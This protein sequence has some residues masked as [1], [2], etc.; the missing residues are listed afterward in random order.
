LWYGEV[1]GR[2]GGGGGGGG[3]DILFC[4]QVDGPIAGGLISGKLT[5]DS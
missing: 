3:G 2:G 1:C 5:S 4:L